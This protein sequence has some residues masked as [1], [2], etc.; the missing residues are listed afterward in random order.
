MRL[1]LAG[2]LRSKYKKTKVRLWRRL[3]EVIS[4]NR[5]NRPSVNLGEISRNSREGS[6]VLVPGKVLGGGN[7]SHPLTVIAFDFSASARSKISSAGGKFVYLH[8][9]LKS[10]D[11]TAK[12]VTVL[13]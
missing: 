13:G 4:S 8:D 6:R 10:S 1:K 12:E 5:R 7:L 11:A 3:S 9:Y 2:D